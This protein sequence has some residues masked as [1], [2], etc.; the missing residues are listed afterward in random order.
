M[1][2]LEQLVEAATKLSNSLEK[3]SENEK[4]FCVDLCLELER[5]SWETYRIANNIKELK[6]LFGG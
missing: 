5:Y 1:S 6:E 2:E 4:K 3:A